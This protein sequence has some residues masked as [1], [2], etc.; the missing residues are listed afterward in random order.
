MDTSVLLGGLI[1]F[2][3]RVAGAQAVLRAVS[4]G[5]ARRTL[6]AWHCCLEFYAVATRLPEEYRLSPADAGR[7]LEEELLGRFRVVELPVGARLE[8]VREVVRERVAGGRLYDA[9]IAETARRAGARLVVTD[10]V[11]HFSALRAHGIRVLDSAACAA[12]LA[13]GR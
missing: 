5:P 11:R 9:H 12:E 10:N 13:G 4:E 2:G 7:L 3:P 8:L 1:E 6:T